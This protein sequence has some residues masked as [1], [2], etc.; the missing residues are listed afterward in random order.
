MGIE[1]AAKFPDIS[2][3]DKEFPTI[4]RTPIIAK[5]IE[6]KVT[7]EDFQKVLAELKDA[8]IDNF[9]NQDTLQKMFQDKLDS[10]S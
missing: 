3:G 7:K 6:T 10:L 8:D 9:K 4:I 5:I 1:K 2:P